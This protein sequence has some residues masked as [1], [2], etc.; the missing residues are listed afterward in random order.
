MR[1]FKGHRWL[2][3]R[4]GKRI[5][6]TWHKRDRL[7]ITYKSNFHRFLIRKTLVKNQFYPRFLRI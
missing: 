1:F 2:G 4:H 3:T 6:N 5:Q 7:N